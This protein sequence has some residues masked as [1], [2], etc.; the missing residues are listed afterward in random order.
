MEIITLQEI[1]ALELKIDTI[2]KPS[3]IGQISKF[4][5]IYCDR[6]NKLYPKSLQMIAIAVSEIGRDLHERDL[7]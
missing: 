4:M 1:Q 3:I 5:N 6:D 7:I 2:L